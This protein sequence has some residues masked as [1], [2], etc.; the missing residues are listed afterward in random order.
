MHRYTLPVLL[1]TCSASA[2]YYNNWLC[3]IDVCEIGWSYYNGMCYYVEPI[4][5][6]AKPSSPALCSSIGGRLVSITS[7]REQ[8]FISSLLNSSKEY[9]IGLEKSDKEDG[10]FQWSDESE[11]TFSQW[12][13]YEPKLNKTSDDHDCVWMKNVSGEFVWQTVKCDKLRN[14]ICKRRKYLFLVNK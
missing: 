4:F 1:P 8:D 2:F 11:F 12:D 14:M 13:S 6:L 10:K 5:T 9:W 3:C 7:S